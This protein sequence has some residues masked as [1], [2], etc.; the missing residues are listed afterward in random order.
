MSSMSFR[1]ESGT[2]I[3]INLDNMSVEQIERYMTF[4]EDEKHYVCN[5]ENM[6]KTDRR[7][8]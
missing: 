1:D 3:T 4:V 8:T 2:K 6:F 5:T 7:V